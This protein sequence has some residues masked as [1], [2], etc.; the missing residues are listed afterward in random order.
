[1][2]VHGCGPPPRRFEEGM[3]GTR[4]PEGIA[5]QADDEHSQGLAQ[6]GLGE[7]NFLVGTKSPCL[8]LYSR[9]SFYHYSVET[10]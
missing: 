1:M 6:K 7:K 3:E 5:F 2:C 8:H 4:V 10:L 9:V